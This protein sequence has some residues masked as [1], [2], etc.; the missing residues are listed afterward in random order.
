MGTL[1]WLDLEELDRNLYRG[2]NERRRAG[3]HLYGGQVAAQAL[4]AAAR[5]VPSDRP[6]H[7]LH[8]YFLRPGNPGQPVLF[9]VERDR[10]GR[11]FSARRVAARQNGEVIF[12]MSASFHVA[13]R[14]PQFS[15]PVRD[16]PP[17]DA[18]SVYKADPW[19]HPGVEIR[20][21]SPRRPAGDRRADARDVVW[22]RTIEPLP[23]DPVAHACMLTFFSDLGSGF[24]NL[25]DPT[26]PTFGPS[27][28]HAVWF[29]G[30][31]RADDWLLFDSQP[32][33]VGFGRGL[34][35]GSVLD[36]AGRL[37]GVY[38]QESL[39]RPLPSAGA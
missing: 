37:V 12:E 29:H 22:A 23:D 3:L 18:P 20:V 25:D 33:K 34:Y 4:M 1:D 32:V 39:L 2:G 24:G 14:G 17:A 5:T 30:T 31:A 13:E 11:S 8:G 35:Q 10:D 38:V 28:D 15:V 16:V 21:V 27:I 19:E 9:H 36:S 6:P 7:S 26:I